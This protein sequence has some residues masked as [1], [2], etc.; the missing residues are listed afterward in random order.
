[1]KDTLADAW[2]RAAATGNTAGETL[3]DDGD[4]EVVTV[5]GPTASSADQFASNREPAQVL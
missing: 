3:P 2:L 4:K 5:G 1:M